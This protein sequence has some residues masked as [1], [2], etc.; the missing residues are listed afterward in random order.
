MAA[1]ANTNRLSPLAL[2]F[3]PLPNGYRAFIAFEN[4]PSLA[5]FE[6]AVTPPGMDGGEPIDITTMHNV[7]SRTKAPRHL[8]EPTD[9]SMRV[10]YNT[11]VWDD[12]HAQ[13]I[14]EETIEDLIND[15]QSITVS[16]PDGAT[17]D[18]FG[19]LKSWTPSEMEDGIFPEADMVIVQS[20]WDHIN[21]VESVAVFT[22][23]VGSC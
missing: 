11:I 18:F 20:N 10:G 19:W 13:D 21:C 4:A 14:T 16:F 17:Y 23:G 7:R 12:T 1:P 9:T 8:I 3:G 6:K 15:N 22:P 5:V 2:G